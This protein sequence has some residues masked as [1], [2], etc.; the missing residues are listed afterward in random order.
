MRYSIYKFI[1]KDYGIDGYMVVDKKLNK[2]L[3]L[4]KQF[5]FENNTTN[6]TEFC[7]NNSGFCVRDISEDYRFIAEFDD[8]DFLNKFKDKY[9]EEFLK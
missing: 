2:G 7:F 3:S 4:Y 9:P 5:H 6:L 8:L 1:P